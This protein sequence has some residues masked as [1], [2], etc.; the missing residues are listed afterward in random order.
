MLPV[1][2]SAQD[3]DVGATLFYSDVD[4]TGSPFR[5]NETVCF[6]LQLGSAAGNLVF[7]PP[8]NPESPFQANVTTAM[9][10]DRTVEFIISEDPFLDENFFTVTIPMDDSPI[11]FTQNATIPESNYSVYKICGVVPETVMDGQSIAYVANGVP[12]GYAGTNQGADGVSNTATVMGM[13]LPIELL[14]FSATP[15][16]QGI[17]L[18][19]ETATELNNSHFEIQRSAD[20]RHYQTIGQVAGHG[21]TSEVISYSFLDNQPLNGKNHYRLKQV[22]FDGSFEYSPVKQVELSGQSHLIIYPNPAEIGS[23]VTIR[24]QEIR[25]VKVYDMLGKLFIHEEYNR[26]AHEVKLSSSKLPRGMYIT[27]INN[28]SEKRL[29]IN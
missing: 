6:D 21:T 13:L 27:R 19:W 11:N 18:E 7:P 17:E 8:A 15:V 12:G 1:L 25:E 5:R 23:E 24:G 26:P 2:L 20:G 29:V 4:G 28:M 16:D 22:D 14:R 9:L 3:P 10:I